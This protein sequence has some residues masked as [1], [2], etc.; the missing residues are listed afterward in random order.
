MDDGPQPP[1]DAQMTRKERMTRRIARARLGAAIAL[2][3]VVGPKKG[4]KAA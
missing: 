1:E 3:L 2:T 4:A